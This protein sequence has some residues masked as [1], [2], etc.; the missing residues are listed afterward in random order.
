MEFNVTAAFNAAC[1]R[2]GRSFYCPAGH[3]QSY[4]DSE[5]DN[6]RRERDRLKQENA[7]LEDCIRSQTSSTEFYKRQSA[8]MKG[9]AT[10]MKN[11]IKVGV[12]PCCN[13]TF[14]DLARHMASQHKDFDNV[15][16]IAEKSA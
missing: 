11:R 16:S 13:R 10:K 14:Q 4:Q 9:V 2:D 5:N 8:A 7:R 12:C 6:V 1:R 15:I 3:R